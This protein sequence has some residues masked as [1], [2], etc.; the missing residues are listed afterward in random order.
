MLNRFIEAGWG[1]RSYEISSSNNPEF[2]SLQ[3]TWPRGLARS[4]KAMSHNS[5]VMRHIYRLSWPGL[6]VL[7]L[8]SGRFCVA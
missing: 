8:L 2:H 5:N 3:G 1:E 4:K 7:P 6:P